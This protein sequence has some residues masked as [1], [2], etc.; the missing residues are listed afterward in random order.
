MTR[1]QLLVAALCLAWLLPGLVAHDPWKPDEAYTF[2]IVYEMVS[3]GSWIAPS[4]AG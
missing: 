3:G 4:V 2:G 1:R